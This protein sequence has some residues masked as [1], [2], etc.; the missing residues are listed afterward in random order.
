M[1]RN[2]AEAAGMGQDR[3]EDIW[4]NDRVHNVNHMSQAWKGGGE[5]MVLKIA[6]VLI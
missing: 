6:I 5:E 1:I 2:E 4:P 3:N